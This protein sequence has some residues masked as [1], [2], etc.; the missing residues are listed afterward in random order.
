MSYMEASLDG[1]D[2]DGHKRQRCDHIR[3]PLYIVV[4]AAARTLIIRQDCGLGMW[5][6]M[7]WEGL[8]AE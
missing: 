2:T 5:M 6:E 1:P 4:V 3:H 7:E 8:W